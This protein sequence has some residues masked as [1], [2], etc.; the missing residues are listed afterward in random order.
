MKFYTNATESGSYILLRG[1]ENGRAFSR[2]VKYEPTLY[3]NK[4][5]TAGSKWKSIEGNDLAPIQFDSIKEAKDFIEKYS[6]V[7]NF[8]IYGLPRFAYS[9]LNEEY[10]GE[11]QYDQNHIRLAN[12]D[13]ETDSK[14][15]FGTPDTALEEITAITVK[16]DGKFFVF[17]CGKFVS[18]RPD[19]VYVECRNE[20]QLLESFLDEWSRNG[21]PDVITGWNIDYYD[22]PYL[23]QRITNVLGEKEAKRLSPWG[24]FSYRK[25]KIMG[26]ENTSVSLSG[27]SSLDYLE[28]YRKFTY[29]QQD[30]YRLDNI[31]S[32]ELGERKLSV[33]G[34]VE[35]HKLLSGSDEIRIDEKKSLSEMVE[36]EKWCL[37][38]HKIEAEIKSRKS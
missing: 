10:R 37:L 16:K 20:R 25:V 6:D 9:F 18:P 7:E 31:A 33:S 14:N 38:K 8:R 26:R 24:Y 12:I 29:K 4:K 17:G 23:V 21:Y 11:I 3:V 2:K 13:I 36:F 32:I 15:G 30:S 34:Q 22:V 35:L 28:L 27:I 5:D 19:I 1:Y